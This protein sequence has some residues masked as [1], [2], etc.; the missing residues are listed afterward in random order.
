MLVMTCAVLALLAA[1]V[2][3][4]QGLNASAYSAYG[5]SEE[6]QKVGLPAIRGT[7][8]DRNGNVLAT[9][10]PKTDIVADDFLVHS[11]A[12]A[13]TAAA[14]LAPLL[15][16]GK[17]TLVAKLT[18]RNGY[19]P[20][21][22]A[23]GRAL[24]SKVVAL[25]LPFLSF[26]P[27][28]VRVEPT[29]NLFAP[30]LGVVGWGNKGLSGLEYLYQKTLAGRSGSEDVMIGPSGDQLPGAAKVLDPAVQGE[31]LV[32]TL[33]EPLQY[34]VTQ[35][36]RAQVLAQ[37]ADSA[38]CVVLDTKTGG[39]LAM[40]SL[41]RQ[42]KSVVPATQNLATN[43]VYQPGSVMKLATFS[44]ALQTGLITPNEEL[45]VPYTIWV[46]GWPFQD[47]EFHPTEQMP[48]TQI[49]AQS[50]NVGT[51][52]IAHMLGPQRLSAYLHALGFGN[53]TDLNWPGESAGIVPPVSQWSASDMGTIPIGTGEAVTPLQIADA[54][55]TVANGGEYI[56]PRLVEAVVG[57]NGRQH[58]LPAPKRHRVL[59]QTRA[60]EIVPMLEEGTAMGTRTM[61]EIAGYTVAGKTGTA[62]IPS[63]TA[64]GYQAGAWN[65]TFVGFVPAQNP[66]LTAVVMLN[67]PTAMYGGSASAPV[68]A[69]IMKYALRH[70]DISP[71]GASGL[72][73]TPS[74]STKP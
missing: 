62:Q 13:E 71:S 51:I 14:A 58:V 48:V 52:E 6:V 46:G 29:G 74:S 39:I 50:S 7:V 20:L 17:G 47:A 25:T 11:R 8:Y 1:R 61:A 15:H 55:N 38:T 63:T 21:A 4:V 72:S 34:E 44:G 37:H 59:S 3:D 31:G 22:L 35:A 40:V 73:G 69:T 60:A 49:L 23:V 28:Q 2:F 43:I 65:A 36:L 70:F 68:F 41:V 45:T 16:V 67:H 27:D 24:V 64:P 10:V 54:Y 57:P 56:P 53:V 18:E 19:V 5:Q 32:L 33:D 30:L 26:V 9:S 66:Q 12:E 42:N